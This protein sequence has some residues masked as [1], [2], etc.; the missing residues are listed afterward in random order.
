[1]ETVSLAFEFLKDETGSLL[2]DNDGNIEHIETEQQ[3]KPPV[4]RFRPA[5][6]NPAPKYIYFFFFFY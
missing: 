1:V 5:Q 3:D 4:F 6:I 2:N